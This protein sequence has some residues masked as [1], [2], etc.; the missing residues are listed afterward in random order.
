M[1]NIEIVREA[2]DATQFFESYGFSIEKVKQAIIESMHFFYNK[3]KQESVCKIL[4]NDSLKDDGNF[5]YQLYLLDEKIQRAMELE[6]IKALGFE[7]CTGLSKYEGKKIKVLRGVGSIFGGE[8]VE[9]VRIVR[10][11]GGGFLALP[12]KN[13]KNGFLPDYVQIEKDA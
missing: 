10:G 5:T 3:K 9:E 4:G 7:P 13:R 8:R 6:R 1:I 2:K 11:G 12:G